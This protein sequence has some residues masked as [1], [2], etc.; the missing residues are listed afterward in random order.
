[1]AACQV[2]VG[3][4]ILL[5]LRKLGCDPTT[6]ISDFSTAQGLRS[7]NAS[8][9]IAAIRSKTQRVGAARLG[10]VPEDIKTHSLRYGGA[11]TMHI[12]GVPDPTL[13]A[14]TGGAR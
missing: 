9:I 7:V 8:N 11:M 10:F 2:R 12:A 6:P 14:I 1:M 3:V 4:N 13:V 5:R